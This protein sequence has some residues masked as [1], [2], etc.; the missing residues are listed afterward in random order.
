[1]GRFTRAVAAL[2]LGAV[3]ALG[4]L[5]AVQQPGGINGGGAAGAPGPVLA[6]NGVINSN[7]AGGSGS[8]R[9]LADNGVIHAQGVGG[10]G[11][12]VAPDDNGVIT[13][14]N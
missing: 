2:A 13:S 6:D 8:V 3:P 12:L 11:S 4:V 9:V 14:H 5:A 10:T 1:M 7:S